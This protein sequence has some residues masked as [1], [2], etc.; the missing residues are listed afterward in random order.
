MSSQP[1]RPPRLHCRIDDH[2]GRRYAGAVL[3]V[4]GAAQRHC[5]FVAGGATQRAG[6][7]VS[8]M[9]MR[10]RLP[11]AAHEARLLSDIGQMLPDRR[12]AA[13]AR[14]ALVAAARLMTSGSGSLRS[15][16]GV[17]CTA[18]ATLAR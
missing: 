16:C 15:S 14:T 11:A 10:I 17:A 4:M 6:L 8:K 1:A 12:G 5:K 13:T 3:S 9:M 18:A 7:H 2:A